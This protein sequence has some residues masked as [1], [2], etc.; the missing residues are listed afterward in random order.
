MLEIPQAT[1]GEM[2]FEQVAWTHGRQALRACNGSD[3]TDK[4]IES[5]VDAVLQ[6]V[7][8][9]VRSRLN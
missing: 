9:V 1:L 3:V 4:M 5:L 7:G 2:N 6:I 8:R